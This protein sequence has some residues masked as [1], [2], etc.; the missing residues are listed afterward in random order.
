[1]PLL[2]DQL[3]FGLLHSLNVGHDAKFLHIGRKVEGF[4][5]LVLLS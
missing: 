3:L 4:S 5:K 1:M 2:D